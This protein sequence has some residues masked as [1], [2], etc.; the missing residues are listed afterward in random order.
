METQ[1][2][3]EKRGPPAPNSPWHS[4]GYIPHFDAGGV[5]QSLSIRLHDSVP[6]ELVVRWRAEH[7]GAKPRT[8]RALLQRIDGYEDSGFGSCYLRDPQVAELVENTLLHFDAQ[9]YRLFEWCIMP[10]HVHALFETLAGHPMSA[11]VQSWKSFTARRANRL[12]GR[13]GAF[14]APDYF[15]RFVRDGRH[16]DAAKQYIRANPVEAGLCASAN[17]WRWSS[18]WHGAR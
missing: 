13:R 12:L 3:P 5:V 15:D 11:V 17:Q 8:N 1:L 18:A 9:R 14:W 16:F 10:N 7:A 4:P 6:A 2:D